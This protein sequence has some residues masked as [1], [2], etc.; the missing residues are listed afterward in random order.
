MRFHFFATSSKNENSPTR[1]GT[2]GMCA[3]N[4]VRPATRGGRRRALAAGAGP[5]VARGVAFRIDPAHDPRASSPGGAE[6]H[7]IEARPAL[8]FWLSVGREGDRPPIVSRSSQCRGREGLVPPVGTR[9]LALNRG[10]LRHTCPRHT[11]FCG[12]HGHRGFLDTPGERPLK[13]DSRGQIGYQK[14]LSA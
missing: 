6:A 12:P 2:R 13:R 14:N 11:F 5:S 9:R 1:G 4:F 8:H 10:L 3:S 7:R